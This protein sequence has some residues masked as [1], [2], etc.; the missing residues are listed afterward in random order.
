MSLGVVELLDSAHQA[1]VALLHQIHH[2]QTVRGVLLGDADYQAQIGLDKML[3]GIAAM[4]I[5]PLELEML[6]GRA[7]LFPV[8]SLA[9]NIAHLH[10]LRQVDF[11]LSSE[12]RYLSDLLQIHSYRIVEGDVG[13]IRQFG[14]HFL[15]GVTGACLEL[16]GRFDNL[17]AFALQHSV[18]LVYIDDV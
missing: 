17:D 18:E 11:L 16:S 7:I 15:V 8:E 1:D 10:T 5:D 9:G 4:G 12:Q 13:E 3:A 6:V 2:R 14:Q